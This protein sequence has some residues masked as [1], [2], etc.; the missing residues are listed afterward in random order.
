MTTFENAGIILALFRI[1]SLKFALIS[2]CFV[3]LKAAATASTS[4]SLGRI[5]GSGP[6]GVMLCVQSLALA[7][8]GRVLLK[9]GSTDR[10][11]NLP[12]AL[13]IMLLDMLKLSRLS[14]SRHIPIQMP[15]PLM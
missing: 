5:S 4:S 1:T 11:I 8:V 3:D 2:H 7:T 9:N 15:H 6:V 13:C 10:R 12:M 14:K